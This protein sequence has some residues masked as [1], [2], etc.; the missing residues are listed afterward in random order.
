MSVKRIIVTVV[1]AVLLVIF[2]IYTI[3]LS[4][5]GP[6]DIEAYNG[7]LT[8]LEG[9]YDP[10]F[11]VYVNSPVLIR[12]VEMYQYV[13]EGS[14]DVTKDFSD[15]HEPDQEVT[16]F[17]QTKIL[18]NPKMSETVKSMVFCGNVTIGD[19][20]LLLDHRLLEKLS[21]GSYVNFD[22]QPEK[23]PVSGMSEGKKV[24]GLLPLDDYT[25]ATPGGDYWEIGDLKVK[26]YTVSMDDLADNYTAIG[27]VKDGVI[28]DE[29]HVVELY[30]RPVELQDYL[31][32]FSSGNFKT[33]VV[34]II[35]G[36]VIGIICILPVIL[37]HVGGKKKE[38]N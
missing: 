21:Y 16:E 22:S 24:F 37:E 14:D 8:L 32:D 34:L 33:G 7:S 4:K 25:Y 30:D 35:V 27:Y 31:D 3:D 9:A 23:L 17:G 38:Q 12:T 26:W 15:K 11:D 19:S 10:D 29:D 1:I 6:G 20:D 36:I 18:K 5:K 13:A 28:G 2:G